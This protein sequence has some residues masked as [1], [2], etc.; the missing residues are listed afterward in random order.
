MA[1]KL[2]GNWAELKMEDKVG[3]N[4]CGDKLLELSCEAL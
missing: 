2:G 3:W 1:R 4:V